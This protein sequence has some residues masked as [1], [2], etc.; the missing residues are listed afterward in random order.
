MK[1]AS[2]LLFLLLLNAGWLFSQESKRN[3]V[4]PI[5]YEPVV[6]FHFLNQ[7]EIDT[8]EN[9]LKPV[10]PGCA[11]LNAGC[12]ISDFDGKLLLF[13]NGYI[14]YDSNGYGINNG[15][16]INCPKGNVLADYYGGVSLFAQSSII[17]PKKGNQYYVF[18]TGMSDSVANNYLNHSWS[19]F[20]VLSF[21][22]VDMDSNNGQ[23]KVIEKNR[24][25]SEH[26]HYVNC[27]MSAVKHSNG[28]DWWL[29]KADCLQNRYQEF[30]VKEDTI[31][32]P[33]YQNISTVGDFCTFPSQLYF[34][35][36]GTKMA[37]SIYGD[38]LNGPT[39]PFYYYNRVDLYDF[40]RCDGSLSYKQHY[41]VPYDT[42]TYA[43]FDFKHGICFSP[44]GN[45][46]YMINNYSVYQI[47]LQDTA[48]HNALF[49]HGIDTALAYFPRYNLAACAPNGKMYIGNWNATRNYMSYI[50]KPNI[51]GLG[52]D[53]VAQG[54]GQAYTHLLSPPNMPNYGLGADTVKLCWPLDVSNT[55]E[56]ET[57]LVC[58]PNP[59]S[60]SLTIE[61]VTNKQG[62]APLTM[63]T[64]L[65]EEVLNT[66]IPLLSKVHINISS[67]PKGLYVIRCAGLSEKVVVE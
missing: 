28:K 51:K 53:F 64:L 39:S 19:E 56:V 47:D 48:V 57:K 36:D 33:Y 46:L 13:G 4:W 2:T 41:I 12:A 32:G 27:A 55:V 58:Y 10:A 60:G 61:L 24:I 3:N 44:N 22:V 30:L 52:C 29:V 9:Y 43:N 45:L 23:G 26:Q 7:F 34:S 37:S 63:Y 35:D 20:D 6:K 65:G 49:I 59:A 67:L 40:D 11:I 38:I 25:L 18:S 16:Y 15:V 50:D 21:C 8:V 17:L 14:L 31:M 42:S 62:K 5:G 54:V 1:K 66:Y